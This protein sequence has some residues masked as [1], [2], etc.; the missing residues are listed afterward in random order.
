MLERI[1]L[2][3]FTFS[4]DS[5]VSLTQ[6]PCPSIVS[7]TSN[8]INRAFSLFLGC[9]IDRHDARTQIP[10]IAS[11]WSCHKPPPKEPSWIRE[12]ARG[13]MSTV[14]RGLS[15]ITSLGRHL[16]SNGDDEKPT[17]DQL[18]MDH[19]GSYTNV[20]DIQ[21]YIIGYNQIRITD[22]SGRARI[23]FQNNAM[24]IDLF[25]DGHSHPNLEDESR[26]CR[27]GHTSTTTFGSWYGNLFRPFQNRIESQ[28]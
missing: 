17:V 25:S 23:K 22:L 1:S 7:L 19:F 4:E 20:M 26:D 5:L 21:G 18:K 16:V 15:R 13:A 9:A 3:S 6:H 28:W 27:K 10:D 11:A 2:F 14:G 8:N 24:K 12:R